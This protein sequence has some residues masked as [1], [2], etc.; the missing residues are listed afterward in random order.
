[1]IHCLVGKEDGPHLRSASV[2]SDW[3]DRDIVFHSLLLLAGHVESIPS[4]EY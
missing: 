1:M 2:A 4:I 3:F